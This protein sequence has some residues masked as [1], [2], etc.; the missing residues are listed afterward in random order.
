MANEKLALYTLR[1]GET[2]FS[3]I[4]GGQVDLEEQ[5]IT[6]QIKLKMIIRDRLSQL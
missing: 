3:L 5:E 2:S 4:L 6:K 1:G